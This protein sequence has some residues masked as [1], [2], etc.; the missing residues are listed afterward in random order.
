MLPIVANIGIPMIFIYWPL[1]LGALVP[2]IVVEALVIRRWVP[3]PARDSLV[4]TAKANVYSTLVGVPLAWLLMLA[5][6]FAAMAPIL[7][8]ELKGKHLLDGE[9]PVIA[10]VRTVAWLAPVENSLHWMIP[11]AVAVLLI[12]SFWISVLLERRSCLKTWK[13]AEPALVRRG[14]FMANLVSY[15]LLFVVAPG[16]VALGLAR[17]GPMTSRQR[18]NRAVHELQ[19]AKNE[20]Q[21]FYA[22]GDAAKE[23]FA[24]GKVEDARKYAEELMRVLPQYHGNWN[25]GNA[26]QD[27][28]L[29]LGR[30]A[31]REG[32]IEDAKRHLIEA[33]KSPGSPQMDT[34][35]PNMSLA[36]DLLEKG[37]R[38]VVLE[39]LSLCRK[40][41]EMDQDRLDRWSQEVKIGKIPDFGANLVY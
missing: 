29:V 6:Q 17:S 38:N 41:W 20:E 32:R 15:A 9:P 30:I 5:L 2:V 3:M 7:I 24:V 31:V 25:Y 39:Y 12:P 16:W 19:E 33:G 10:F 18:L 35:G 27:A 4:G 23:S 1:M 28:H 14:V 40:F 22:L 11:V 8:A 36:Q 26:I 37:E 13:T 34:F 21:R